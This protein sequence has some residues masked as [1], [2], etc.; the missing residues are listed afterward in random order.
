[1]KVIYERNLLFVFVVIIIS[2]NHQL[3]WDNFV[4]TVFQVLDLF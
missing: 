3:S 1:M 4:I 2:N